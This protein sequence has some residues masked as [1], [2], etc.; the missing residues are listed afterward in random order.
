MQV[1]IKPIKAQHLQKS[2][3]LFDSECGTMLAKECFF[4][5]NTSNTTWAT[6]AGTFT[7]TKKC[8]CKWMLHEYHA[9]RVVEWEVNVDDSKSNT[10]I[11]N[12]IIGRDWIE[13]IGLD[14]LLSENLMKWD[15]TTVP[16]RDHSWLEEITPNPFRNDL[17]SMHDPITTEVPTRKLSP[18]QTRYTVTEQELSYILGI[19]KN[20]RNI[21]FGQQIV[22]HTDHANLTCKTQN[23]KRLMR[24]RLYIE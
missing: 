20:F 2:D 7:T 5:K 19:L 17:F 10:N 9:C 23:S 14:L 15:N 6:K 16:M 8:K 3:I 21:L 4:K 11:H 22:V 18:A 24:W 12:M 1:H 13:A